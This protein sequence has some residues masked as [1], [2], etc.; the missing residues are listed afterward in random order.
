[1]IVG[2]PADVDFAVAT[3]FGP[4]ESIRPPTPIW[5][6]ASAV[7]VRGHAGSRPLRPVIRFMIEQR[8]AFGQFLLGCPVLG[9]RNNLLSALP[10]SEKVNRLFRVPAF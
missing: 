3:A 6:T 7:D 2:V 1:V 10:A 4:V 5:L 9:S 8:V